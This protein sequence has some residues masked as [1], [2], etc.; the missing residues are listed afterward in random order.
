MFISAIV[1]A[2]GQG[3]RFG[4]KISKPLVQV[5]KRPAIFYCLKVLNACPGIDEIIL[6]TNPANSEPLKK[7]IKKYRIVKIKKVV[8]GGKRRQDSVA[9][10]LKEVNPLAELVLIHDAVRPFI[11]RKIVSKT[12]EEARNTGAAVVAVPVKATI[13]EGTS[14]VKNTL[15]RDNLWEAQTPQVFKKN[16]I[17]KAYNK[18]KA[19]SV[20]DDAALVEKLGVR[21]RIV[22]GSYSNIKITTPEDLILAQAIA[23][24]WNI[25]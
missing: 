4:S 14:L 5:K 18:Y 25:A 6:V 22:K 2:A 19:L 13:K 10:G 3:K 23:K 20:T 9:C 7:V 12:I 1:V 21:V 17:I 24:K 16:L 15:A 11:D 8:L